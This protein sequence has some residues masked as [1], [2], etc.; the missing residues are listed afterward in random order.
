MLSNY[1]CQSCFHY[2]WNMKVLTWGNMATT[3]VN[4]RCDIALSTRAMFHRTDTSWKWKIGNTRWEIM[5][6]SWMYLNCSHHPLH[7]THTNLW[8]KLH[9]IAIQWNINC[10]S[11]FDVHTFTVV[12]SL[13]SFANLFITGLHHF[14]D[15]TSSFEE[16]PLKGERLWE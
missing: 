2:T 7:L 16:T 1:L 11:R 14:M 8:W 5:D 9:I 4:A 6:W 3:L 12:N 10:W 15:L 13:L